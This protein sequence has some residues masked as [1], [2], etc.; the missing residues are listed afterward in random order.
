MYNIRKFIQNI[1]PDDI[2]FLDSQIKGSKIVENE[3]DVVEFDR[4]SLNNYDEKQLENNNI[5]KYNHDLMTDIFK[6]KKRDTE[7]NSYENIN[8]DESIME[9]ETNDNIK[10]NNND[11]TPISHRRK[12][13][14]ELKENRNINNE[15]GTHDDLIS[16][17]DIIMA[18]LHMENGIKPIQ[19]EEPGEDSLV[20]VRNERQATPQGD[21]TSVTG[22]YI[23]FC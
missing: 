11:F 15:S 23:L 6:R 5:K 22:M 10:S 4:N 12:R 7:V 16:K 3:R 18:K 14:A 19:K 21:F 13:N 9:F 8:N 1:P 20:N 2:H 17:E